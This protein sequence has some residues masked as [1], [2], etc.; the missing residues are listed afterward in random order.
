MPTAQVLEAMFRVAG[1]AEL[2][3]RIRPTVRQLSRANVPDDEEASSDISSAS[4]PDGE[5]SST[6]AEEAVSVSQS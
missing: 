1:H 6:A 5:P 4:A 2:A 3:D